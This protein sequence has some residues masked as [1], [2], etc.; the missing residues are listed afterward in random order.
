MSKKEFV[1]LVNGELDGLELTKLLCEYMYI[2]HYES[3]K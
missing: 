1:N 2:K 3:T